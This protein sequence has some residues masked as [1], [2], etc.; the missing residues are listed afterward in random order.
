M[1]ALEWVFY[2]EHTIHWKK[3]VTKTCFAKRFWLCMSVKVRKY[4]H[5]GRDLVLFLLNSLLGTL[6]FSLK[7]HA[8]EMNI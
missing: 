3:N 6:Q 4:F 2:D 8:V 1:L 7:D 5:F